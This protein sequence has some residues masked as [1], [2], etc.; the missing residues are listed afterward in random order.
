M[1][2]MILIRGLPGSGK[3]TVARKMMLD[4]F[5]NVEAD[6]FFEDEYDNY[7]FDPT[8]VGE[9]HKWCQEV[10]EEYMECGLDVVVSNTFTQKWEMQPYMKLANKYDYI[11]VIRVERGEYQ[12]IHDVP[13]EVI[14][15]MK[16][17]WEE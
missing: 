5:V 9:A 10:T 6:M 16:A 3:T 1:P 15:K 11:V 13:Q 17:R 7:R 12:N 2:T 4:G 14:E 8:R